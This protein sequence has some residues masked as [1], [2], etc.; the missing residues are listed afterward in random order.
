MLREVVIACYEEDLSWTYEVPTSADVHVYLKGKQYTGIIKNEFAVTR[1]ENI[2]RESHTFLTHII[3]KYHDLADE[4]F[5]LQGNPFD[6]INRGVLG[7]MLSTE[8]ESG[9]LIGNDVLTCDW[10]GYPNHLALPIIDVYKR[11]FGGQS[12]PEEITFCAGGQ[13]AVKKDEIQSHPKGFYLYAR[14]LLF[15]GEYDYCNPTKGFVFERIWR[16]IFGV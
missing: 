12:P 13:F 9:Y 4:T 2:G 6:H 3:N 7:Q 15:E 11:L 8:F 14:D 16:Y 1:L 5:F 10:D